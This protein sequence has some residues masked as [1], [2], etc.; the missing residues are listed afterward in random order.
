MSF[1]DFDM[2]LSNHLAPI[3]RIAFA[4]NL[5]SFRA[6]ERERFATT[7]AFVRVGVVLVEISGGRCVCFCVFV[8]YFAYCPVVC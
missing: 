2:I 5:L 7:H 1:I 3:R 6:L 4:V 8:V